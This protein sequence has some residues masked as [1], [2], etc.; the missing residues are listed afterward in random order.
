MNK[1]LVILLAAGLLVGIGTTADAYTILGT[2]TGALLGGDITDPENDIN[3][4]TGDLLG[5]TASSGENFNW[6]TSATTDRNYFGN[7]SNSNRQGT[8]DVFDNKVS[9]ETHGN[10]KWCCGGPTQW[11]AL[12]FDQPHALTHFT[13]A[14]GGDSAGRRPDVFAIQGSND[15]TTGGDGTWTDIYSYSN[16]DP[17]ATSNRNYHAGSSPFTANGQVVLFESPAGPNSPL[18]GSADFPAKLGQGYTWFRYNVSSTAGWVGT[19]GEHQLGEIELFGP[20]V[21]EP[22]TLLIWSLLAGLGVGLGWRRRK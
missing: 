8:L 6:I 12:E 13:L 1:T 21:P 19:G 4:N 2:G 11:V 9:A 5:G 17:N 16:D 14:S 18:P 20:V 3:D 10:E 7:P 15:S 22:T